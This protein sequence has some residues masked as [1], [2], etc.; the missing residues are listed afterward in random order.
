MGRWFRAARYDKG[1]KEAKEEGHEEEGHEEEGEAR[2]PRDSPSLALDP[3]LA[4]LTCPF[5]A[6]SL[7]YA[8]PKKKKPAKKKPA[9]KA[10]KAK[11]KI[12][13]SGRKKR[14]RDPA[15]PKRARTAF[16]YFLDDF[17]AQFKIDHPETKGIVE[18]TKAG[19]AAWNALDREKRDVYESKAKESQRKYA[20]AKQ[21][22]IESGGPTKF[23][24]VNGPHR[25]PTAYFIFL[26]NFRKDYFAAHSGMK[27]VSELSKEAGLKWRNL[28][29]E[30]RKFFEEKGKAVK[31]EYYKI[32]AMTTEERIAYLETDKD[33]YAKFF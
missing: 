11:P 22:Y 30:E 20:E 25:P 16:N 9:K 32:K 15:A 4:L 7:R 14:E 13:K 21:A 28:T 29:P 12:T 33:P 2:Y 17:R 23:K 6:F 19:S 31:E 27:I 1:E 24:Y 8:K 10:E 26:H 18:V 3:L 5:P